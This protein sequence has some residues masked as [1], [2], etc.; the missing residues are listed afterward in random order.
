MAQELTIG[1]KSE[2]TSMDPHFH[3]LSTNIQVGK[4]IFEALTTQDAVQ[5]VTPGLAE[6]WEAIDDTTWRFNLRKGVKFHDGSDFTARDVIYS[7]CRVPLVE[8]SPSAY[9]IFTG[10]FADVVAEDDHTVLITTKDTNPLLPVELW[11]LAIISADALGAEDEVTFAP[12][13]ECTG[14]GDVPQAPA[15]N[16]PEISVGTGPYILESY[17]RGSELT[18]TRFDD[19]WDGTPEWERVVMRPITSDGPRVAALLAGDVDLIESPP[20]Q[21]IPRI[22]DGGFHVVDA[23]SNRVI[24]LHMQQLE[25]VPAIEGTDGEN[26]LLDPRVREAISLSINREAIAE[27]IMGGYAQPAGELLPPPMF[28]TSGRDVDPYDPERAKELLAE[29]GYPDGF[30]IT[31]GTPNDRYIND[32]QVAQAVAQMMARIGIQTTVDAS[33]ASQFFSRR[34]ALEF[35]IYMAGWG[36]SSG[37]MSSPLKSLVATYDAETGTGTTNAGRYSNPEMDALLADAMSTIDDAT[38]DQML[39]DA[40]TMVL[41]DYGI[42]PL[43]YEQTVWAM[44]S[45]LSYEPR[46]DQY[47]M[48]L[49]VKKTE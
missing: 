39:Q 35:P 9:T 11:S 17:T 22:E 49:E 15:F 48:A 6:S 26:P 16:S 30:S 10:G 2:A 45:E 44:K 37:D 33:T 25:D 12:D 29:A 28:G 34:N 42:I 19:Y 47:T 14:M 32:E 5:K 3:Q 27:R 18:L 23:L 31:L 21:D 20:I 40:E 43:H 38:R 41:D 24:Y 46:V 1:L 36:A 8:N 7:F 4:N 13:G